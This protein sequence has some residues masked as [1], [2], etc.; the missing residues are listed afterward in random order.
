[1]KNLLYI[2]PVLLSLALLA[3]TTA[4]ATSFDCRKGHSATEKLIC[5]DTDLSKLDDKLGELFRQARRTVA[6]RRAFL[7]DSNAKW[8]WREANCTD[9]RCLMDWYTRRIGE[10]AQRAAQPPKST[11]FARPDEVRARRAAATAA[12]EEAGAQCDAGQPCAT[13][14]PVADRRPG[15]KQ[16]FD[17]QD[18]QVN[19]WNYKIVGG[20]WFCGMA[21]MSSSRSQ[22]LPTP[23][24][25]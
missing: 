23:V 16:L 15:C 24:Y 11:A 14:Q 21:T 10:L 6:D 22:A 20:D 17:S 12:T 7:A 13:A 4:D 18:K 3:P 5:N 8:S 25:R 2:P 9:K 19:R 1:M